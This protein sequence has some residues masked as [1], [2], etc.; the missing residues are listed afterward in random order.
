[1]TAVQAY[2][3]A[4]AAVVRKVSETQGDAIEH[5]AQRCAAAIAADHL[6]HLFGSGHSRMAV[7]EIWPRYGSFPGFHPIVELSL[8]FHNQVV[9]ANGQRQAMF[10]ENTPGFAA[11]ILRNF[12]LHPEDVMIVFST[13]GTSVVPVEVAMLAR[14]A[15]LFT[16]GVTSV[17]HCRR[18][19]PR[20]P[21]GKKLLD[22]V[23]LSLDNCAPPGDAAVRVDGLD[24]PVGP[25]STIGNTVI[26][27]ALKCRVAEL[28]TAAGQPPLVLAS[29]LTVG[30]E[31][32]AH[33]FDAAYD[34]HARRTRGALRT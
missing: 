10:V 34:D 25:L 6:V 29:S 7:E 3:D 2:F 14:Q 21:D 5:A 23:D 16:I 15:G 31:R 26:A 30:P 28:L 19:A 8:T 9:G 13:S 20:Q 12:V 11:A 24:E 1:M 33:L 17:E 22:A 32:S 4:A 27:N 18:A